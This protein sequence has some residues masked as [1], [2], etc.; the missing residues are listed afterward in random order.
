MHLDSWATMAKSHSLFLILPAA[1][2]GSLVA[3]IVRIYPHI[4][5]TYEWSIVHTYGVSYIHMTYYMT[6]HAY[7]TTRQTLKSAMNA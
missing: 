3:V 7:G 4:Y 2:Q 5:H 6:C 1:H